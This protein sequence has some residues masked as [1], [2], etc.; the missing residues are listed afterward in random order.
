M[1]QNTL[2]NAVAAALL[3]LA[4]A[5][6]ATAG[7]DVGTV[8]SAQILSGWETPTGTHV[9]GL[10]LRL[11]DGWKTYWR[12]PGDAGIPPQFNWA[13]S[14]NVADVKVHW[15]RPKVF[16]QNGTHS[17]GYMHEVVL[18]ITITPK[19]SAAPVHLK[20]KIDLG[21]CENICV[22][23]TLHIDSGLPARA[24]PEPIRAALAAQPRTAKSAGVGRVTC[25]AD[26]ITDGL[27]L[28]V[29]VDVSS[30]GTSEFAVIELP[31]PTI[32]VSEATVARATNSLS[33]V[34][35]LVPPNAAPFMLNRSQVRITLLSENQ[36]IEINGC[37]GD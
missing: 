4:A 16:K 12:T 29:N 2:K 21:V 1:I 17:L 26:P 28:T 10:H 8:I 6:P 14:T 15:P 36:A 25:H 31:D 32:W 9:A 19:S 20:G 13:G 27:R 5:L 33:A 22:P 24:T 3:S 30:L 23:A 37:T 11:S 18:P 35:D 34:S 7:K